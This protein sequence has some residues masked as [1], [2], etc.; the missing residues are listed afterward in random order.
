MRWSKVENGKIVDRIVV[1]PDNLPELDGD[2]RDDQS[3]EIGMIDDGQG[4]YKHPAKTQSEI[5]AR[6]DADT[7]A[8]NSK[9]ERADRLMLFRVLKAADPTYT[10]AQFRIDRHKLIAA[11]V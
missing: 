10:K 3:L 11:M 6:I 5:D 9:G 2:W 7:D 1:D 4:G 8:E